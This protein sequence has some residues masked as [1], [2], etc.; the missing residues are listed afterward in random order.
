[1]PVALEP[2]LPTLIR[3]PFS[4][5]NW[6]YE[7]KWDGW[8]ALCFIR[9]GQTRF[10]SRKKNSLN[11]RFPELR[12][13]AKFVKAE[14]AILDGEIVALDEQGLPCFEGLRHRKQNCAV[15]FY[16]FDMLYLDGFDL[17][18]CP[19]I[20]RK[21]ALRKI[22]PRSN[23]GRIRFTDHITAKGEPLFEKLEALNLEGMVLK[24]KDSVYSF[25]RCRDWLKIKTTS[26]REVMQKR[27]EAWEK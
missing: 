17:T 10:L 4:D 20:I 11:E 18:Q 13:I 26:G 27:M 3:K 2:M 14:N 24:R 22:L 21:K 8:R 16:C 25:V 19:L 5:P 15:V 9:D 7:P 23:T 6:I 12:D 1:M